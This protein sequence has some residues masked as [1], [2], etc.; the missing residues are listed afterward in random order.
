MLI[1]GRLPDCCLFLSGYWV[2]DTQLVNVD[3]EM[4][5]KMVLDKYI[6]ILFASRNLRQLLMIVGVYFLLI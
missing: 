4:D 5:S 1:W 6:I 3:F 2:C